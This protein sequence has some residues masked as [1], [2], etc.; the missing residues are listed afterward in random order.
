MDTLILCFVLAPFNSFT[1]PL[2]TARLVACIVC[3]LWRFD[4]HWNVLK[5]WVVGK[6]LERCYPD[7]AFTN[8]FVAIN[9]AA[10]LRFRVVQMERK[11]PIPIR[12]FGQIDQTSGDSSLQSVS[13]TPQQRHDRYRNRRPICPDI[14]MSSIISRRC[15]KQY[16][17]FVPCPAVVSSKTT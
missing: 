17:R 9:P 2:N 16:P 13:R 5:A 15:S 7:V 11:Q 1:N 14:P 3:H 10:I 12:Q 6:Q 8:M 4:N